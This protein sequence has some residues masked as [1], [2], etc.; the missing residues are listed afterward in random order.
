MRILAWWIKV[1]VLQLLLCNTSIGS[2]GSNN[3]NSD[4]TIGRKWETLAITIYLGYWE[5]CTVFP[6]T[7]S[8]S[9]LPYFEFSSTFAGPMH[10]KCAC[11]VGFPQCVRALGS[12]VFAASEGPFVWTILSC[13]ETLWSY[14]KSLH[15]RWTWVSL[16]SSTSMGAPTT[17]FLIFGLLGYP[18]GNPRVEIQNGIPRLKVLFLRYS[19]VCGEARLGNCPSK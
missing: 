14:F 5:I 17:P 18:S 8:L 6:M 16:S 2:T 15:W 9:S 12:A 13:S 4:S 11:T 1:H 7:E 10:A 19:R 3:R